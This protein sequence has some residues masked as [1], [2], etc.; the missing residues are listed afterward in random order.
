MAELGWITG[1]KRFSLSSVVMAS[2]L[3]GKFFPRSTVSADSPESGGL[4]VDYVITESFF[5]LK[6]SKVLPV[7]RGLVGKEVESP[8]SHHSSTD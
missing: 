8:G 4:G 2:S 7:A 5:N 1:S 3:Q 6:S